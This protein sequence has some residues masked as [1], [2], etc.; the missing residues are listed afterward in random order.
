MV[1][2]NVA[3]PDELHKRLKLSAIQRDKTLKEYIIRQLDSMLRG[4]EQ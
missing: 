4:R 2:I 1:N 3:I